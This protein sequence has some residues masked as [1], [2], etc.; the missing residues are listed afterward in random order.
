MLAAALPLLLA[1]ALDV[2]FVHQQKDTCGAA[3]L[4]MVLQ[5]WGVAATHD[6]IAGEL[7]QPELHGIAGSRLAAF[8]AARG[9][10][11]IAHAGDI[12]HL[13]EHVGK[14]RP[15]IVAWAMGRGRLHD[16]VVTGFDDD[17]RRVVVH[18]PARGPARRVDLETFRRRWAGTGYW[19]LLIAPAP[20]P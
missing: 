4:A 8:A 14:G 5:Y 9:M 3:A 2:P 6:A 16:V 1:A 10:T 19:T 17:G 13:R 11:A 18:D 20:P 7:L 15:L 12:D